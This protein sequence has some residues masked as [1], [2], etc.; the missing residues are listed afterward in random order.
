MSTTRHSNRSFHPSYP[1]LISTALLTGGLFQLALPVLAIGAPAGTQINN[2]A[3]ATYEDSTNPGVQINTTSNTVTIT[4][5]EVAGLTNVPAGILDANG[6]SVSTGDTVS[7]D[8][9]VTNVGNDATNLFIPG[10]NNITTQG[11]TITTIQADLDNNGTFETTFT[12]GTDFTTTTPI[13]ADA[14]IRVRV[15][16]TVTANTAGAPV[17]VR[18]GDTPPNDNSAATQNQASTG[19]NT[20]VRT[21]NTGATPVNGQREASALNATTL[22]IAV[23]TQALATVLKTMATYSPG[24]TATTDDQV[25]Y[26]LDLRIPSSPPPGNSFT[27]GTLEG[28]AITVNGNTVTRILVS[29]VIPAGT[30]FDP[31]FTPVA[32]PNWQ[33]VYSTTAP[34][35][36]IAAQWQTAQPAAATIRRVGFI[37]NLPAGTA[38]D[39]NG[40]TLPPGSTTETDA[41]GFRFRVVTTN[42]TTG[43]QV[44]N[45][46]QAFGETQGDAANTIVYDESGDQNP[47]NFDGSAP[48]AAFNPVTD[49][50]VANPTTQGTDNSNNNTG[51]GA[52]G[53]DNVVVISPPGSILNGPQGQPGATGP[54]NQQDDFTNKTA[55]DTP[56]GN[57]G[58]Y[59]PAP[60]VFTNTVQNPPSNTSNLSNVVLKPIAP[61]EAAAATAGGFGA[62]TDLPAG[63][64]VTI[65]LGA[66]TATYTYNGTTF[67]TTDAP[68]TIATLA[69]GV[70]QNYTVA[71]NLPTVGQT[72]AF[73]VPIVSFIDSGINP[74]QFDPASEPV[75]NLTIDRAYTGF[76][77]LVKQFRILAADGVTVLQDFPANPLDATQV[78][79]VQP[80][81]NQIIQYRITYVNISTASTGAASGNVL[82]N[83]NNLVI[84]EDGTAAP[85]NW[86]QFTINIT[87]SAADPGGVITYFTAPIPA[88]PGGG[89]A[90]DPGAATTGYRDSVSG[91]LAPGASGQFTF[92]RRVN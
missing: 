50:G 59:D 65:T 12:P 24:G 18:L 53:E 16:G 27:V 62:N 32:P 17:S 61:G 21:V 72:T 63:T 85:N 20:D 75:F 1:A 13:A 19:V 78:A 4:V 28:T 39:A 30:V 77:R 36:A 80:Q 44:A 51:Q 38:A 23:T 43:G 46:A 47:N 68:V 82:L 56:A 49:T 9:L 29:D 10:S 52:G 87:N 88:A 57:A 92:R 66:Q 60:I 42:L 5:A 37:L 48:G 70:S 40:G 45:I 76:V 11:L 26:R 3:T 79:T 33:V 73:P 67:T 64:T 91:T 41:N 58:T 14:S 31:G 74:G 54:T 35:N 6:G 89:N 69:P 7:F 86:A 25:T 83:A 71:V 22:G 55:T 34:G 84:T 15:T 8:F 90:V 2:R 81:P